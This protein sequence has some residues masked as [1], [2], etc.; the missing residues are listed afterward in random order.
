MFRNYDPQLGRWT[1]RDPIGFAGGLNLYGFCVNSPQ[2]VVDYYGRLWGIVIGA[3]LGAVVGA[4][5]ASIKGESVLGG[6]LA[7]AATGAVVGATMGLAAGVGVGAGMGI[8]AVG[9]AAGAALG[10]VIEQQFDDR[11][12]ICWPKVGIKAAVGAVTGLVGGG[13]S[14]WGFETSSFA[15][16]LHSMFLPSGLNQVDLYVVVLTQDVQWVGELFPE[17]WD[18]SF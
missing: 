13:L 15:E 18:P 14:G 9:S 11:P 6:A 12:G 2:N 3:V 10:E 5:K 8:G 17:M 7:G 16:N 1:Q 4:V